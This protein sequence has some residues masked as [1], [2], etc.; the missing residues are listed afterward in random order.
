MRLLAG[1]DS[2]LCRTTANWTTVAEGKVIESQSR[3]TSSGTTGKIDAEDKTEM[4]SL[5]Y[6]GKVSV[7][8]HAAQR[9]LLKTPSFRRSPA[10]RFETAQLFRST[11]RAVGLLFVAVARSCP[12]FSYYTPS[13]YAE[14]R[15]RTLR[16]SFTAC[17][18]SFF[19]SLVSSRGLGLVTE[20]GT[21][22]AMSSCLR[23]SLA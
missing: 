12:D 18:L 2:V 17:F 21:L 19:A 16:S 11:L 9:L 5:S 15:A 4:C 3:A 7:K 8:I 10:A 1:K 14:R 6:C 22:T 23:A 13:L 20:A